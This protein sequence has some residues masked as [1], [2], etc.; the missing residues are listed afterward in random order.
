M[1]S[2]LS[3]LNTAS[4]ALTAQ[5]NAAADA[6]ASIATGDLSSALARLRFEAD[7]ARSRL[8]AARAD[9]LSI[10]AGV[11]ADLTDAAADLEPAGQEET[12]P[13]AAPAAAHVSDSRADDRAEPAH[14][15]TVPTALG[16]ATV[17]VRT[18]PVPGGLLASLGLEDI[19]PTDEDMPA[20]LENA[21]R[22]TQEV[23]EAIADGLRDTPSRNPDQPADDDGPPEEALD[24]TF[25]AEEEAAAKRRADDSL[26]A[27][28]GPAR[29]R[30][31]R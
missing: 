19:G 31:K 27:A 2:I 26:F 11:L 28:N 8:A 12:P 21:C 6:V 29:K 16:T 14:T 10:V 18:L 24:P 5:V 1:S 3:N 20:E 30:R 17:G 15:A 23:A 9:V 25:E 22:A 7:A 4:A 13:P